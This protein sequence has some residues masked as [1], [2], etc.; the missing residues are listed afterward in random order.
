MIKLFDMNNNLI[1]TFKTQKEVSEYFEKSHECI[2]SYF[3]R[4]KVKGW[5]KIR[6]WR[7]GKWFTMTKGDDDERK[8]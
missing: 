8:V 6:D 4:K 5:A 1:A 7:T 2:R 3:H